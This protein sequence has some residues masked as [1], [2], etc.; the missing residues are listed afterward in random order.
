MF[1]AFGSSPVGGD[2]PR[3]EDRCGRAVMLWTCRAP[4][5]LGVRAD[6]PGLR[7]CSLPSDGTLD[8]NLLSK[9]SRSWVVV[10]YVLPTCP[11]QRAPSG[12]TSSQLSTPDGRR[13]PSAGGVT[14]DRK[15]FVSFWCVGAPPTTFANR[16]RAPLAKECLCKLLALISGLPALS[17]HVAAKCLRAARSKGSGPC[18]SALRG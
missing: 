7:S 4:N 12:A 13:T 9:P 18:A 17:C 2:L 15:R 5:G 11:G 6:K 16:G 10:L 8:L 1:V 14:Q 3:C